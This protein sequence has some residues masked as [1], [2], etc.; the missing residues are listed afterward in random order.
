LFPKVL[1]AR[2]RKAAQKD[3]PA[4]VSPDTR[5]ITAPD[6]RRM[7]EQRYV[8]EQIIGRK[9][10][11]FCDARAIEGAGA[12]IDGG[13]TLMGAVTKIEWRDASVNLWIGCTP[14]LGVH[15]GHG[16]PRKRTLRW[17]ETLGRLNRKAQRAGK[18]I[19]V[20]INSMSDVFDN[21]VPQ[22]WRDELWRAVPQYKW[23]IFILVTK[24]IGN[25]EAMLPSD[26]VRDGLPRNIWLLITTVNQAELDRDAPK[27]LRIKS[28]VHG[29][30]V[31]P[32]LG[33]I[34]ASRWL[35]PWCDHGSRPHLDGS[36][37]T[38]MRCGGFGGCSGVSWVIVGGESGHGARPFDIAWARSIV[39]QCRS[40]GVPVFV[41]QLGERVTCNGM[42]G[43]DEHWPIG[44]QPLREEMNP[45]GQPHGSFR[46][47]LIDKKSGDWNEWPA[48]L[49]VREFPTTHSQRRQP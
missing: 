20:F 31:E 34:D 39:A 1:L 47:Y 43:P 26:W 18:L 13:R 42:S 44:G 35:G 27:L 29:L 4:K 48:D 24:R 21:D 10:L 22:E 33:A 8:M 30:S 25:A 40:A 49:R 14:R 28:W 46:K 11:P 32:M 38:C 16:Q 17:E 37:V 36:G 23:L 19:K 2:L 3:R 6:G 9:L 41:K 15:W 5:K 45:H 7:L 12:R